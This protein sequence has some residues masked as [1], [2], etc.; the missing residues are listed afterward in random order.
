[1]LREV[2]GRIE[3]P[4]VIAL[5]PQVG[6]TITQVLVAD[7]AAIT[8]GQ[9]LFTLDAAPWQAIVVRSEAEIARAE[10]R[11]NQ[12]KLQFE[13][14]KKL[15]ADQVVSPQVYEDAES[16]LRIAEA[17]V[18][19]T[20]A[21]LVSAR[22]D[23]EHTRIVAP[24][25]GRIGQVQ[26]VAGNLAQANGPAAGTLLAV[27]NTVDPVDVAFDLDEAVW[28]KLGDQLRQ[29][30]DAAGAATHAQT[31]AAQRAAVRAVPVRVGLSSETGFPHVG[32]VRF[33]DN[34]IDPATGTIRIR[35]SLP[36]PAGKLTP[37][38]FARVQIEL[39]PPRPVLLVN[40]RAVLAQLATRYVLTVDDQ[41]ATAFRPVQ[42]GASIDGL[43]VVVGGL[44]PND[45]IAVNNLSKIFFPGMPVTA[46]PADMQTLA[47]FPPPGP[48][49]PGAGSADSPAASATA[50]G[51]AGS[52]TA[53]AAEKATP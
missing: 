8:A 32:S 40:E 36:N 5:R 42:L 16:A 33:V 4:Q 35:A 46:V 12:A 21:A 37:G 39:E 11:S 2:T 13:R 3:S 18:A 24:S 1:M 22:I 49:A 44:G 6:G 14:A 53:A 28:A 51:S 50:A 10:A 26:A 52:A 9:L 38:A 19:A 31:A 41:G 23:L 47:N 30:A 15:V 25:A 45:R 48:A 7:G 43:R 20:R 27:L 29:A 17:D 34:K